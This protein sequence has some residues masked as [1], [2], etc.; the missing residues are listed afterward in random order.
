VVLPK[1]LLLP[2]LRPSGVLLPSP[3]FLQPNLHQPCVYYGECQ[4]C[5]HDV[6][7]TQ[8]CV[9]ATP[10]DQ[11]RPASSNLEHGA[12]CV[13]AKPASKPVVSPKLRLSQIFVHDNPFSSEQ[14]PNLRLSR[15]VCPPFPCSRPAAKTASSWCALR[16]A[17]KLCQNCVHAVFD[18]PNL[19]HCSPHRT[20]ATQEQERRC[21]SCV[22]AQ[23]A[24]TC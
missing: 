24:S 6:L 3:F 13:Q 23:T 21:T 7:P 11:A 4:N 8:S 20:S 18:M 15:W 5:V 17:G 14:M 10:G 22:R 19:C 9:I 1:L 16:I 12:S 2:N